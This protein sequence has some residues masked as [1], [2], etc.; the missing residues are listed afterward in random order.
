MDLENLH[1]Q[2]IARLRLF[3]LPFFLHF[4]LCL[5]AASECHP[6][7]AIILHRRTSQT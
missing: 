1:F 3:S 2:L 6:F 7:H 4:G 5:P